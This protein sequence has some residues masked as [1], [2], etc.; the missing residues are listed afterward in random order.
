MWEQIARGWRF[1]IP[2][3]EFARITPILDDLFAKVRPALDRDL[4]TT[5]PVLGFRPVHDGENIG[6]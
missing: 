3:D 5:A 4:S 2:S 1:D 6:I